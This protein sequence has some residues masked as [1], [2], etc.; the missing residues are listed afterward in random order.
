MFSPELVV[1]LFWS[2][3][4]KTCAAEHTST[5]ITLDEW[6]TCPAPFLSQLWF[7]GRCHSASSPDK[8]LLSGSL[9][10]LIVLDSRL[11]VFSMRVCLFYQTLFFHYVEV[12]LWVTC[13]SDHTWITL[14]EWETCPPLF[15]AQRLFMGHCHSASLTSRSSVVFRCSSSFWIGAWLFCNVFLP[16]HDTMFPLCSRWT[17][18]TCASEPTG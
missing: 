8:Q 6:E 3:T 11:V 16:E 7:M 17:F 10:F 15:V 12:E 18:N 9:V 14:D 13:A 4:V 5:W 2:W 1:P